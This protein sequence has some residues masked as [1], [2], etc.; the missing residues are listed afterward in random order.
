MSFGFSTGDFQGA[1]KLTSM[2][3]NDIREIRNNDAIVV[4]SVRALQVHRINK[5]QD[6][7]L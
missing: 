2:I 1:T 6:L 5:M 7:L 3:L 4:L